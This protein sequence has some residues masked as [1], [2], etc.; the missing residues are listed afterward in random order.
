MK[1]LVCLALVVVMAVGT[2]SCATQSGQG[3]GI[4]A[5]MGGI[6]GA[7][8]CKGKTDCIVAGAVIGGLSGWAIGSYKDKQVAD[9][10][11]AMKEYEGKQ[12]ADG[13]VYVSGGNIRKDLLELESGEVNPTPIKPGGEAAA[14]IQYTVV[15]QY[16]DKKVDVVEKRYLLIDGDKIDLGKPRSIQVEQGTR[17]SG[18]K[19]Q[20]PESIEA[21]TY[22]LVTEVSGLNQVKK[23]TT[24]VTVKG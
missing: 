19:F 12:D 16:A 14:A 11:A 5:A 20:L 7:L 4:G 24:P 23:I 8:I 18:Y 17:V 21:G 13:K 1:R 22:H 15:S 2:F 3:A 10:Q 6:A 9:R